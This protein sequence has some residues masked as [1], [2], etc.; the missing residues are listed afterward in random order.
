[1]QRH[2]KAAG[3]TLTELLIALTIN[4]IVFAALITIVLSTLNHHRKSINMNR[5]NQQLQ[6]AITL[7]SNDIR[8]AGYWANA[9]SDV[10]LH[11]NNNPFMATG[12]DLSISGSCILLSYDRDNNGTA[13]AISSTIDD[14][15]YGF[16]LSGQTLQARPPGAPFDCATATANWENITDSNVV[17]VTGLSFTLTTRNITTGPGTRG[18][19]MRSVDISLTGC[20]TS[21][22]TICKTFTQH[23]RIRNDK[24]IP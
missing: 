4:L 13:P 15:R 11:Q 20:L 24:Y 22:A 9:A 18:I 21:D 7:M 6:N 23:V 3:F 19:T 1:M 14:E 8:R 2:F 17:Q 10:G 16:R 12:M 5:L